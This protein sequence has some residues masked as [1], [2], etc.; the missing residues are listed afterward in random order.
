MSL[1][2]CVCVCAPQIKAPLAN[3][4][5]MEFGFTPFLAQHSLFLMD[6]DSGAFKLHPVIDFLKDK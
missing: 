4:T 2:V 1:D 5:H 3:V 6:Y